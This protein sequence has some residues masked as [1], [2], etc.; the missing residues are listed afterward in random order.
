[1]R[2]CGINDMIDVSKKLYICYALEDTARVQD[3]LENLGNELQAKL[4]SGLNP[5]AVSNFNDFTSK[6]IEDAEIFMVFISESSKKSDFVKTC[7]VRAQNLNRNILPIE[8]DKSDLFSSMPEEFKFRL[9]PYSFWNE[10][11]KAMLLGQ[12][13]ASLGL[14][15]ESGDGYGAL[16]HIL[17][18]RDAHVY[19][20]GEDLGFVVAGRDHTIRL[21]KGTHSLKIIDKEDP[22]LKH[23]ITCV[24]E[25]YNE[26]YMNVPLCQ[27]LREKQQN[28]ERIKRKKEERQETV[29]QVKEDGGNIGGFLVVSFVLCVVAYFCFKYCVGNEP[30][31]IYERDSIFGT[32]NAYDYNYTWYL[33]G[34][35]ATVC[36]FIF[37]YSCCEFSKETKNTNR[38][39]LRWLFSVVLI[40]FLI[41]LCVVMVYYCYN[42]CS[43]HDTCFSWYYIGLGVI[44][45]TGLGIYAIYTL[46]ELH[47]VFTVWVIVLCVLVPALCFQYC[48]EHEPYTMYE[49]ESLFGTI[50]AYDYNYTWYILGGVALFITAGLCVGLNSMLE[51]MKSKE[52]GWNKLGGVF[53]G[54]IFS[55]IC[56]VVTYHGFIYCYDNKFGFTWLVIG[57]S[58]MF[59]LYGSFIAL[60]KLFKTIFV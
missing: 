19:R 15:V 37:G 49:K 9:D 12:L 30:Y 38:L 8:I 28:D 58:T 42:Y 34:F 23:D 54:V 3:I 43:V 18:D 32:F 39:G 4:S 33:L 45:Y 7:V 1:M 31:T 40:H 25:N 27:F 10:D 41:G 13:K 22:S 17:T 55:A 21:K 36:A 50:N 47:S 48:F 20:G 46:C 57:I 53:V 14:N 44:V 59:A 52:G 51:E 11:S 35:I 6:K 2:L 24:V 56:V 5:Q 16:M 26:Q 60:D 29:K